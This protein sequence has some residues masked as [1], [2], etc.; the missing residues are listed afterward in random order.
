[1][2][3]LKLG[4]KGLDKTERLHFHFQTWK[5]PRCPLVG[6]WINKLCYN[7][8]MKY[9]ALKRNELSSNEKHGGNLGTY[10]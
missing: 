10:D 1:M 7:Q 5:Q 6:G 3:K 8:T 9:P 4:S 2:S